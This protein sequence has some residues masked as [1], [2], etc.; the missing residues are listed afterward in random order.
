MSTPQSLPAKYNPLEAA[1]Y[2]GVSPTQLAEAIF[3]GELVSAGANVEDKKRKVQ[4][5]D[6]KRAEKKAGHNEEWALAGLKVMNK[7]EVYHLAA[8]D[9]FTTKWKA[10]IWDDTENFSIAQVAKEENR[11]VTFCCQRCKLKNIWFL[12]GVG[13]LVVEMGIGCIQMEKVFYHD[14]DCQLDAIRRMPV[15][16]FLVVNFN[17]EEIMGET[18]NPVVEKMSTFCFHDKEQPAPPGE[19]INF[20]HKGYNLDDRC[21]EYLPSERY[22][23][24]GP[25]QHRMAMVRFFFLLTAYLNMADETASALLDIDKVKANVA[26]KKPPLPPTAPEVNNPSAHL[27]FFEISLLFGGHCMLNDHTATSVHQICHKDGET[28]DNLV[29]DNALLEG[30]HKP[31]SFI[32][33]LQEQRTIYICTPMLQVTAEK[34]QFIWFNGDVPHGGM[35]YKASVDG[36][37]WKPAIHGHLDSSHHERMQ[38]YFDF[39]NS[40]YVYFPLEHCKFMNDQFP[41][42]DKGQEAIYVA[43]HDIYARNKDNCELSLQQAVKYNKLLVGWCSETLELLTPNQPLGPAGV[44]DPMKETVTRLEQLLEMS[45]NPDMKCFVKQKN[46][47]G[48]AE[49]NRQVD[50]LLLL[51]EKVGEVLSASKPVN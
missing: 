36:L 44:L 43:L 45:N 38:G 18:Y 12:L 2:K 22:P 9:P 50:A 40:D 42:L 47:K 1:F 26:Q 13:K 15:A 34:G 5:T 37:D 17:F 33:P 51:V 14:K 8:A 4:K 28:K 32:I 31:G 41:V 35:T 10:T 6:H 30:L 19:P 7:F 3:K 24:L 27:A 49:Q 21:Y 39:E 46:G 23:E 16:N 25:H 11:K 48:K 20:G 29:K